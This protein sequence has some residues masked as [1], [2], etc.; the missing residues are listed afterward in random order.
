MFSIDDADFKSSGKSNLQ[1]ELSVQ[2]ISYFATNF[3]QRFINFSAQFI[4]KLSSGLT[5][6]LI[7]SLQHRFRLSHAMRRCI[8]FNFH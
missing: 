3:Q 6:S 2:T 1:P 8:S 5:F 4:N 7:Q